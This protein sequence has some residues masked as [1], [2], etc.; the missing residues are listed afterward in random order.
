MDDANKLRN[1]SF[2]SFRKGNISFKAKLRSK[3][4]MFVEKDTIESV[5]GVGIHS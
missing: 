5:N 3:V 4:R 1:G 2:S